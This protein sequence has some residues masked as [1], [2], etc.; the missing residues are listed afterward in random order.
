MF[1]I[2]RIFRSAPIIEDVEGM[3]SPLQNL[4]MDSLHLIFDYMSV[5]DLVLLGQTN[6]C[7]HELVQDELVLKR[8]FSKKQVLFYALPTAGLEDFL[9]TEGAFIVSNAPNAMKVLRE[10][11]S[12]MRNIKLAKVYSEDL[13]KTE[14]PKLFTYCCSDTVE[15]L[16]LDNVRPDIF[17]YANKPFRRVEN[18][19]L[20]GFFNDMGND[21]FSFSEIFPALHS[22]YLGN[23]LFLFVRQMNSLIL[24]YPQLKHL[25][26]VIHHDDIMDYHAIN[27]N[28][29]TELIRKNPQIQSLSV[30]NATP[31]LLKIIVDELPELESLELHNFEKNDENEEIDD[32]LHFK[33]VRHF[34]SGNHQFT[35]GIPKNIRFTNK[36]ETF[37][38]S[39]ID[40]D[41]SKCLD[42]IQR[43]KNLKSIR[44]TATDGF[45][46]ANIL[47]LSAMELNAIDVSVNIR[48]D[49]KHE[50]IIQFIQKNKQLN[51]LQL[52]L[53]VR[54]EPCSWCERFMNICR[55]CAFVRREFHKKLQNDWHFFG[56]E[57]NIV[58]RR[59]K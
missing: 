10:Y 35:F 39:I 3:I 13:Y 4:D 2:F 26:V 59:K 5:P 51:E 41:R 11:G 55:K 32:Q 8:R 25:H 19:S 7:F 54:N 15:Q 37:E 44:I 50:N 53:S 14:I 52:T 23:E 58:I 27:E 17:N 12:R 28:V 47:R 34:K 38:A 45:T 46:N 49:V 56:K 29:T 31:D 43:Y 1:Q 24:E 48:N 18:I 40:L 42:F 9:E 30:C 57:S 16:H 20:D 22:L 36:L 33:N 21:R 6:K